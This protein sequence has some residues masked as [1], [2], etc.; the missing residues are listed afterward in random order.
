MTLT[1]LVYHAP[2]K[3]AYEGN[4]YLLSTPTGHFNTTPQ[5]STLQCFC[6]TRLNFLGS[7]Q[8]KTKRCKTLF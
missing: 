8:P 3:C 1:P 4:T 6:D 2:Q 5:T 7:K